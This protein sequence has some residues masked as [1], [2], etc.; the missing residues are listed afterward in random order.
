[1]NRYY[2]RFIEGK[3]YCL[4]LDYINPKKVKFIRSKVCEKSFQK[5][6]DKLISFSMMTLPEV[7][8]VFVVYCDASRVGLQCVRVYNLKYMFCSSRNSL[9]MGRTTFL[10]YF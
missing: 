9:L 3:L 7:Y 4:S 8:D 6:K 2:K 10:K 1:M 5:L